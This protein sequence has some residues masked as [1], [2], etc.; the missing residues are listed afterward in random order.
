ME[1]V[2][3]GVVGAGDIS[4]VYLNAI[5]RSP[6]LDLRAIA[7]RSPGALA[8]TAGKFGARATTVEELL[9]DTAVELVVNL[10]PGVVH[11][12]INGAAL[13][14][15][16]HFYSEKPFA[17]SYE[18]ACRLAGLAEQRGLLIG[19]APDTFYGSAHQA[20]RKAVDDG[21]IGRV[22][23]GTSFLG[24]PGLEH[25]HPN[26]EA[27]Y[28]PGGEPPFDAGPYYIAMWVHLL[29]PVKRVFSV[30]GSGHAERVIRRGKR[31][32]AT[33]NVAVDTS[34]NTI[35]EFEGASVSFIISLDVVTPTL[36]PGEL[37]GS[38]GMIALA[39]PMF[40]GGE[41]TVLS[42]SRERFALAT[43]DLGFSSPNRRD[44]TGRLVADYR[45]AGL[46]DLALAVRTGSRHRTAPDFIVHCV[47][48]MEA[49]TRSAASRE[50]VVLHSHCERP[51]PIDRANDAALLALTAS[52]FDFAAGAD[53]EGSHALVA[54]AH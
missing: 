18:A 6:A 49:I 25:F 8:A 27:F 28:Q 23:F 47:E 31:Q 37:Y 20:A 35:L 24:L 9:A 4:P 43:T 42:P 3:I 50:V 1:S 36:R 45:G 33:F 7:T 53:G 21:V 16:K 15:G 39:D 44:H 48:V 29:G 40:F 12:A 30:S 26:P 22:V 17:L 52:P 46:I 54:S 14:A 19:S 10:T 13:D 34:F 2:R 5:A 41:P 32:G 51:E 11:E 38:E